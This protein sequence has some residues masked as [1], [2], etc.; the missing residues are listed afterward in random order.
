MLEI[1]DLYF[2]VDEQD[3]QSVIHTRTIVK[4]VSFTFKKG[5]FYAIT[6]PNGSGKTTIAKLIMGIN[7]I[8]SGSVLL[9]G[10]DI[11]SLG[12]TE[13]ARAGIAYSFQNPARFKGLT[14]RDMLS[15]SA[16]TTDESELVKVLIRVGI[17]SLDFLDKEVG[18]ALSG[19]EI[20][21]IEL[22]TTIARNPKVAIYDEPD[23][24]IDL[25]TIGP[26]IELL[27]RE[28]DEN[29]AT[30]IVVSH[31][32]KFLQAAEEILL[33]RDGQIMHVGDLSST[34]PLLQDLDFCNWKTICEGEAYARCHR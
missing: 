19:G 33:I 25:W 11:T 24:G 30:T 22:A 21:K 17:C 28:R 10:R 8:T 3:A 34:T 29:G 27:K 32:E 7:P 18:H 15:I 12:V 4:G 13:R 5:K 31:N 2:S 16:G 9:E 6:G 14:F 20:K 26:M 1:K 23:T